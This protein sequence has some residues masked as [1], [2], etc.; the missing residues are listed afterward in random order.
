MLRENKRLNTMCLA[1]L[2]VAL[3]V[4]LSMVAK[5]PVIGHIGL[6]LGYIVL[7]VYCWMFGGVVGGVVG[8]VGCCFVSLLA[9]G[10]FPPGWCVANLYIGLCCGWRYGPSN[11]I[12]GEKPRSAQYVY[13]VGTVMVGVGIIKTLIECQLYG[14]PLEVKAPKNII[15]AVIDIITMCIGLYIAPMIERRANPPKSGG[16]DTAR[17]AIRKLAQEETDP[18]KYTDKELAVLSFIAHDKYRMTDMSFVDI[19]T[20]DGLS[21]LGSALYNHKHGYKYYMNKLVFGEG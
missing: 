19:E 3:Y 17:N 13:T 14:I 21:R 16:H 15:A 2:G 12:R 20:A 8:A 9:S 18:S 6:D 5:I 4:A 11:H 1:A 10:W 7:A